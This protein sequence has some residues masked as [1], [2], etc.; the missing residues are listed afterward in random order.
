MSKY[1]LIEHR[2]AHYA[3]RTFFNASRADL[4]IAIAV[5]YHTGGERLTHKAAGERYLALPIELTTLESARL[6][7]RELKTRNVKTLNI[8]G[9]G[10]YTLTKS[11]FTQDYVNRYLFD[12]LSHVKPHW[13]ID[14]IVTGGQTGIDTAGV[15]AACA[16]GYAVEVCYPKGFRLR[17]EDGIDKQ[18]SERWVKDW[19]NKQIE[20]LNCG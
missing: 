7:Y 12:V 1:N 4:T 11:G 19:L 8:A 14:L 9:N 20:E 16:L 13:A 5:N 15:V 10:I 3:P 2:S 18:H 17:F 6:L